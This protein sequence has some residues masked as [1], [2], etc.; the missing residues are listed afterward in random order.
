[1]NYGKADESIFLLYWA[2]VKIQQWKNQ[3]VD[4]ETWEEL[5]ISFYRSAWSIQYHSKVISA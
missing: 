5:F 1:M 4:L 3:P 2:H